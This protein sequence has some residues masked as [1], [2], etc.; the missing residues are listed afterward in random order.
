MRIDS[1]LPIES[2]LSTRYQPSIDIN[3]DD[4]AATSSSNASFKNIFDDLMGALKVA[5][6]ENREMTA[7]LLMGT[8]EDLPAYMIAGEKSSI[9]FELNVTARTKVLDAY[10]EVMGLQV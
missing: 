3:L 6:A 10:K 5:G 1:G 8:L 2:L 4:E 7:Q 9:L